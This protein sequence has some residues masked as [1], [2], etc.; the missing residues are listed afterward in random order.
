M[1]TEILSKAA[2][3]ACAAVAA[4]TPVTL[5]AREHDDF[6]KEMLAAHNWYRGQ[7]SAA[8]LKWD[9]GLAKNALNWAK[10]C[11]ENPRHQVRVHACKESLSKEMGY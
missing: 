3:V 1:L 9:D 6:K 5:E 8:P 7:H 2:I 4:A 11:S 10:R